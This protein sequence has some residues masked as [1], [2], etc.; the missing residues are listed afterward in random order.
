LRVTA[1][2]VGGAV[3]TFHVLPNALAV[4]AQRKCKMP[5]VRL[6]RFAARRF[7]H[8]E[9]AAARLDRILETIDRLDERQQF[10]RLLGATHAD[11]KPVEASDELAGYT[12]QIVAARVRAVRLR[13]CVISP[14][15]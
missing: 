14:V 10:L 1:H 2:V 8:H 9:I 3:E 4:A 7:V 15:G 11:A 6:R 12:L 5:V 13:H